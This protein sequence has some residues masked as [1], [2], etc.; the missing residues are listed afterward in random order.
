MSVTAVFITVVVAVAA[1][2]TMSVS[3]MQ[4]ALLCFAVVGPAVVHL[5]AA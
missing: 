1:Q 4:N 5:A 2:L 3:G